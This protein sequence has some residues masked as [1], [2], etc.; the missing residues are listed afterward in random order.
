MIVIGCDIDMTV[1]DSDVA[2][3]EWCN[4]RS[5]HK[6]DYAQLKAEADRFDNPIPYDFK[7]LFP[8][9][10]DPAEFWRRDDVYDNLEPRSG[11]VECLEALSKNYEIVFVSKVMGNHYESKMG[12]IDKHFPFHSGLIATDQ[13]Q[14]AAVD[15]LIDDRICNLNS[16]PNHVVNIFFE[17]PFSQ[18]CAM[19][20]LYPRIYSWDLHAV[21]EIV[22]SIH[23]RPREDV[24]FLPSMSPT[25]LLTEK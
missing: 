21:I 20:K 4:E 11:A 8:D 23:L 19:H 6:V 5:E 1:V 15:V 18:D 24:G 17:T 10:E 2:W 13:K 7:S 9:I 12:F 14:F 22:K 16:M 25:M 3:A